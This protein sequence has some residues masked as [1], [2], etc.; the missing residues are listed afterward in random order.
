MSW[1]DYPLDCLS[2]VT[3]GKKTICII[4]FHTF[5]FLSGLHLLMSKL[6]AVF[7]N[8]T[9]TVK[10]LL[11]PYKGNLT[12]TLNAGDGHTIDPYSPAEWAEHLTRTRTRMLNFSRALGYCGQRPLF[13]LQTAHIWALCPNME[14]HHVI[15][16]KPISR[17]AHIWTYCSS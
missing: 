17:N 3:A 14:I 15:K 1:I 9:I 5:L 10:W 4:H 8:V 13:T 6:A 7:D 12:C 16:M 11:H 2:P